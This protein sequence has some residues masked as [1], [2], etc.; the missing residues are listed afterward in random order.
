MV[1]GVYGH[2]SHVAGHVVVE[3]VDVLEYAMI[4][5]LTVKAAIVLV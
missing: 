3:Y 5:H 2:V 1:D 4:L